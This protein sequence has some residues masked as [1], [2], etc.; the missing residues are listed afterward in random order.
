MLIF[1]GL[2]APAGN[3]GTKVTCPY[4]SAPISGWSLGSVDM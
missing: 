4:F 2:R 1:R 3:A